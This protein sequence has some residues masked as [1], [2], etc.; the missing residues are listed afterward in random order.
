MKNHRVLKVLLIFQVVLLAI[1]VV[2]SNTY[3]SSKISTNIKPAENNAAPTYTQVKDGDGA[4]TYVDSDGN[5]KT[6]DKFNIDAYF[7]AG[8]G[9]AKYR[10]AYSNLSDEPVLNIETSVSQNID[11]TIEDLTVTFK[12]KNVITKVQTGAGSLIES[13]TDSKIVMKDLSAGSAA[14]INVNL[15]QMVSKVAD[16]YFYPSKLSAKNTVVFAGKYVDKDGTKYDFTKEVEYTIDWTGTFT[17]DSVGIK[18]SLGATNVVILD[19]K[20]GKDVT[21]LLEVESST[22]NDNNMLIN[23]YAEYTLDNLKIGSITPTVNVSAILQKTAVGDVN[24]DTTND[25]LTYKC[26]TKG[27]NGK[28]DDRSEEYSRQADV[29]KYRT[30]ISL[31]YAGLYDVKNQYKTKEYTV[32]CAHVGFG[33]ANVD[34]TTGMAK[35]LCKTSTQNSSTTIAF[36]NFN[37]EIIHYENSIYD[38]NKINTRLAYG[39]VFLDNTLYREYWDLKVNLPNYYKQLKIQKGYNKNDVTYNNEKGSVCFYNSDDGKEY[40]ME[41]CKKY[42]GITINDALINMLGG[43]SK[44]KIDIYSDDDGSEKKIIDTITKSG[45]YTYDKEYRNIIVYINSPVEVNG[46]TTLLHYVRIDNEAVAKKYTS[47]STFDKFTEIH[48]TTEI[49][50]KTDG[51]LEYIKDGYAHP[52]YLDGKVSY[53]VPKEQRMNIFEETTISHQVGF[54]LGGRNIGYYK[55]PTIILE[56]PE[57]YTETSNISRV[58]SYTETLTEREITVKK[59]SNGR[60][61]IVAKY[62]GEIKSNGK[63]SSNVEVLP[64]VGFSITATPDIK[65]F[66]STEASGEIRTF[67]YTSVTDGTGLSSDFKAQDIYDID[68]DGDTTEE[69]FVKSTTVNFFTPSGIYT[70]TQISATIDGKTISKTCPDILEISPNKTKTAKVTVNLF[71]G[72]AEGTINNLKIIGKIPYQGNTYVL[73]K[74]KSLESTFSTTMTSAGITASSNFDGTIYYSTKETDL[75]KVDTKTTVDTSVWKTKE[76]VSDWSTIKSYMIVFNKAQTSTAGFSQTVFEYNVNLPDQVFGTQSFVTHAIEYEDQQLIQ[77]ETNKTGISFVSG[78]GLTLNIKKA[79]DAEGTNMI[80]DA[81]Y[82][83]TSADGSAIGIDS[84]GNLIYKKTS[85]SK[86]NKAMSFT[87]LYEGINYK[88]TETVAPDGYKKHNPIYFEIVNENNKYTIKVDE[89][90]SPKNVMYTNNLTVSGTVLSDV[91]IVDEPDSAEYRVEYYYQN[92]N[93]TYSQRA[94]RPSVKRTDIVGRTVSVTTD[95]K[96]PKFQRYE[97]ENNKNKIESGVVKADNSLV[98]KVYFK[99]SKVDY[100]LNIVKQKTNNNLLSGTKFT[101]YVDQNTTPILNNEEVNGKT[102][103]GKLDIG[104]HTLWVTENKTVGD[105]Y[106]NILANKFIKISI[107]AKA[108]GTIEILDG[109]GKNNSDYFEVYESDKTTKV[110]DSNITSNVKLQINDSKNINLLV[111]NPIQYK[112]DVETVNTLGD[113]IS[114]FSY[115]IYRNNT[116]I[117][118]KNVVTDIEQVESP[119]SAGRYEYYFTQTNVKDRYVNILSGR[120]VKLTVDVDGDGNLSLVSTKLYNG[121]VGSADA[122]EETSADI[123]KYISA[124]VDNSNPIEILKLKVIYPTTFNVEVDK[125]TTDDKPIDNTKIEISS[126]IIKNQNARYDNEKISGIDSINANGTVS[127]TTTPVVDDGTEARVS[128]SETYVSA[129]KD[130]GYYTYEIKEVAP[131]GGQYVNMLEG[132]KVVLRVKVYGDGAL[133]LVDENGNKYP[134]GTKHKYTIVSTSGKA[135]TDD[136]YN[137]VYV[138]VTNNNVRAI[139][140]AEIVNPIKYKIAVHQSVYGTDGRV[141]VTNMPVLVN[142][143]DLRAGKELSPVLATDKYTYKIRQTVDSENKLVNILNGYYIGVDLNIPGDG[144]LKTIAKNGDKTTDSYRIYKDDDTEVEFADTHIDDFVKVKITKDATN[145][146]TLNIYI[147]VPQELNFELVKKD[148][149]TNEAMN[150]VEFAITSMLDGKEIELKDVRNNSKTILTNSLKTANINNKDG[151][152]QLNNVLIQKAGTYTFNIK[153]TTPTTTKNYKYKDKNGDIVVTMVV[154]EG[155]SEY[156][157]KEIKTNNANYAEGAYSDNDVVINVKNERIKG[158]YNLEINKISQLLG[159]PLDGSKFTIRAYKMNDDGNEED[160]TLYNSVIKNEST[161]VIP[162]TLDINCSTGVFEYSVMIENDDKH[163]IELTEI[164]A[165][166]TYTKLRDP[167]VL[168]IKPKLVGEFDD[169]KYVIESVELVKGDNDGLVSITSFENEKINLEVKN[170]QF[171]LS[172]RQYV[173]SINEED[174]TRWNEIEQNTDK[175]VTGESTTAEYY[176]DKKSLRIYAGQE[177]IYTYRVYNEGQIDGYADEITAYLPKQLEF[178]KDDEFNKDWSVEKQD[179]TITVIKNSSLSKES[180]EENLIKAFDNKNNKISYVEVQVKCKIKDGEKPK[181]S[182][183]T[184]AEITKYEGENRPEVVDRDSDMLLEYTSAEELAKYKQNEANENGYV[185]GYEDDDDFELLNIERFDLGVLKYT[186][187]INDKNVGTKDPEFELTDEFSGTYKKDDTVNEIADGNKIVYTIRAYNLGTVDGYASTIKDE[188]PKEFTFDVNSQI[189]KEYGW[190]MYDENGNET[191]DVSVAKY[192]ATDYLSKE[193]GEKRMKSSSETSSDEDVVSDGSSEILD[194]DSDENDSDSEDNQTTEPVNPSMIKGFDSEKMKAPDYKDIKI[195]LIANLPDQKEG[196]VVNTVTVTDGTDETGKKVK[197]EDEENNTDTSTEL[198]IVYFDLALDKWVSKTIISEGEN[199]SV[200][201]TGINGNQ[202][203]VLKIDL[204]KSH[205]DKVNIKVEYKIKVT[206]E[207][208]VP[209]YAKEITDYIPDGFMFVQED[210]PTWVASG[211]NAITTEFADKLLQPG[212]T[213]TTTVI[214]TWI[215]SE[216]NIGLKSNIAEITKDYNDQGDT[217]DIDSTPGNKDLEEDDLGQKAQILLTV[218][219]G[220][221]FINYSILGVMFISI[222][223]TGAMFI[224]G[225]L[226]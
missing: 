173:T 41:D 174:I 100:S 146:C 75:V 104:K 147:E 29:G 24:Y 33:N 124:T 93:G 127:G 166:D 122:K 132:Y 213:V 94:D 87:D 170:N 175:L 203:S 69:T 106:I 190:K 28:I 131:A 8:S 76:Q 107:D 211:N 51:N 157:I 53:N 128:Y 154:E 37:G 18:N 156:V 217:K 42:V 86:F 114:G 101:A 15:V 55:D 160:I 60:I 72:Y 192:V 65:T 116:L 40:N 225:K 133:D 195:E 58:Y 97:Y 207:G 14:T 138:D 17:L 137:Y 11:Y 129:N 161:Q 215:N 143:E 208:T 153:E 185:P 167:I 25:R 70:N 187:S 210:N 224:K 21:V 113:F 59:A 183:L 82:E 212:E 66:T 38:L 168:K 119:M 218:K 139:L 16:L 103:N 126:E 191:N 43:E 57:N 186:Y 171:D 9:S 89:T 221:D 194:E 19:E 196:T 62:T 83:L 91:V 164:Q 216:D 90:K 73:D 202:D 67:V 112:V 118:T 79:E 159:Q 205:L 95:D 99:L 34:Y 5:T 189:N 108:D 45:E 214:L 220:S 105:P 7:T 199:E 121:A 176:N 64:C 39:N 4:V 13:A 197:D 20:N 180:S 61:I 80:E 36:E 169:A 204:K 152:I 165:P 181:Q 56:L 10:G 85:V 177:V 47:V 32:Q 115:S 49:Y 193:S 96:N 130:K 102:V 140:N 109:E 142:G 145:E 117:A 2:I 123:L 201:S 184:V 149:D 31:T 219:T 182:V 30:T 111:K 46:E 12:S 125:V 172:L 158:V 135:V 52:S 141:K 22:H 226:V 6:I 1:L 150:D 209:G 71:N 223:L 98:L 206:N 110:T 120:Y 48:S 78:T 200:E 92:A 148:V 63:I 198:K 144:D 44:A 151:V 50:G 155:E 26:Y 162:K 178:L 84:S 27:M 179:D 81:E 23:D 88:L 222:I 68:G 134:D 54:N 3:K 35:G 74:A 188:L 163:F 77:T 136:L